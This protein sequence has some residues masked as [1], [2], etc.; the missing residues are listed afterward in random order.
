PLSA[1]V[2]RREARLAGRPLTL[3]GREFD[4]L[5]YLMRHPGVVLSRD[6]LLREVWGY[7]VPVDT[8]TVDVHISGLRQ[9]LDGVDGVSRLIETV[10][11]YGYRLVIPLA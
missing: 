9:K 8:R 3:T 2:A 7:H 6:A 10:R 1:D 4:L 11:G 5:V